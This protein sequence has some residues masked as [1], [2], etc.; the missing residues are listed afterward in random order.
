MITECVNKVDKVEELCRTQL[1]LASGF[2]SL[3]FVCNYRLLRRRNRNRTSERGLWTCGRAPPVVTKGR[4]LLFRINK[5]CNL[6]TVVCY[7]LLPSCSRLLFVFVCGVG[8]AS[9][10]AYRRPQTTSTRDFQVG[11]RVFDLVKLFTRKR[12]KIVFKKPEISY[13]NQSHIRVL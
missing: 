1:A 8:F 13:P 11:T 12:C 6:L 3:C 7:V 10:A 2:R 5:W 9:R 4:T